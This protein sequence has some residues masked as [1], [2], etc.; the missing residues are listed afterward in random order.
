MHGCASVI[1]IGGGD[2]QKENESSIFSLDMDVA[3]HI[4]KV[5]K[6]RDGESA[7]VG[8]VSNELEEKKAIERG[9]QDV[10]ELDNKHF[11]YAL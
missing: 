9:V 8:S 5:P 4:K 11:R 2:I 7:Q 1:G 6:K 10:T 3:L